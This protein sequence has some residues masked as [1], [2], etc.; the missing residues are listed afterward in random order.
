MTEVLLNSTREESDQNYTLLGMRAGTSGEVLVLGA[1]FDRNPNNEQNCAV[2][3]N[4]LRFAGNHFGLDQGFI[5]LHSERRKALTKLSVS[6]A[7]NLAPTATETTEQY[8]S[9]LRKTVS[10]ISSAGKVP[11]ILGG[12]HLVTLAILQGITLHH[13]QIQVIHL[14]AHTDVQ[15]VSLELHPTN[16]NFV[17]YAAEL[18]GVTSW[19]QIG[20]RAV[21]RHIPNFPGK[22]C[23]ARPEQLQAYI[24]PDLP[25]YLT[26]DTDGFDPGIMPAVSYPVP[27]GL[28]FDDFDKILDVVKD[29][30]C[31][32]VGVDWVEYN[33]SFDNR[34]GFTACAILSA[35][36]SILELLEVDQ[37]RRLE[38]QFL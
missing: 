11:F 24:T 38:G 28:T 30:N 3:P 13:S 31:P 37:R 33:P 26:I 34:T 6:D 22:V 16:A 15:S 8:L 7:G 27:R 14:D 36:F 21:S 17:N 29:S 19:I 9:R 25:I 35:I 5:F 20:I 10:A 18:R 32:I 4:A 1:P 12:D 2:A 23:G